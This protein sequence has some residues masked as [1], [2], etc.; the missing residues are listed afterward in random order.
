MGP[1][2]LSK[3]LNKRASRYRIN[4]I[5]TFS[6]RDFNLPFRTQ[7]LEVLISEEQYL[8]LGSIQCELVKAFLGELRDL[9]P[10]YLRADVGADVV[11]CSVGS[12]EVRFRGICAGSWVGEL[13]NA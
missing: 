3:K 2:C 11:G 9:D 5:G 7:I 10:R 8:A 1:K 12:E 13:C 6:P 4:K